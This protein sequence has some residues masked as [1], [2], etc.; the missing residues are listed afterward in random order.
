MTE[1]FVFKDRIQTAAKSH[2]LG[3]R[4]AAKATRDFNEQRSFG[5]PD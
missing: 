4:F 5:L 2:D 3:I 1:A